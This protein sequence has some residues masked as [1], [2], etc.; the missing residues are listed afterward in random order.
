MPLAAADRTRLAHVLALLG[1]P[2]QGE[3]DAAALAADRLV[4]GRGL[5]WTDV[6]APE[7]S[8]SGK[9]RPEASRDHAP[10]PPPDFDSNLRA[11]RSRPDLLSPWET[12][13]VASLPPQR[14]VSLRQR[15]KLAQI[16]AHVRAAGAHRA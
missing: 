4:R 9:S 10:P 5:A 8:T 11:C 15:E 6:L 13:F 14:R 1:S 12:D 3:R 7:T 16:A 2:H